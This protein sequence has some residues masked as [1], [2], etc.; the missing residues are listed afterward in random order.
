MLFAARSPGT[1]ETSV[2]AKNESTQSPG[3]SCSKLPA[4]QTLI[5]VSVLRT[6]PPTHVGKWSSRKSLAKRT[7]IFPSRGVAGS[8]ARRS[9][10]EFQPSFNPREDFPTVSWDDDRIE[11][12]FT[13]RFEAERR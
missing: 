8:R 12:F 2:A 1:A 5:A 4:P 13:T 9:C 7:F 11:A 3:R 10:C 6:R